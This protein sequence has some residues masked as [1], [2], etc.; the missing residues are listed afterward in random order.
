[1]VGRGPDARAAASSGCGSM[2]V[3]A[4]W[5]ELRPSLGRMSDTF[6]ALCAELPEMDR[7]KQ[8]PAD[9]AQPR[10]PPGS[11]RRET[12]TFSTPS[13]SLGGGLVVPA[14]RPWAFPRKEARGWRPSVVS[15]VRMHKCVLL[16]R[17]DDG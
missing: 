6:A 11:C 5:E 14:G 17:K 16:S 4:C 2:R 10:G 7:R 13:H 1:M 8:G 12:H 3:H 15:E 9:L